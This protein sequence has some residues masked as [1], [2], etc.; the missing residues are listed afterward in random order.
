MGSESCPAPRCWWLQSAACGVPIVSLEDFD[1]FLTRS[2]AGHV[3][4]DIEGAV[5]AIEAV[6]RGARPVRDVGEVRAYLAEAHDPAAAAAAMEAVLRS[7]TQT[8]E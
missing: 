4:G 5:D 8:A 6:L 7:V 1:G 2:G 3:V